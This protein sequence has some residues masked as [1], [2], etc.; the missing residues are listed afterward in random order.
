[1]PGSRP[2][3]CRGTRLKVDLSLPGEFE[4]VPAVEWEQFPSE[5]RVP[6]A[7][8][9]VVLAGA[10]RIDPAATA[11]EIAPTSA[12]VLIEYSQ[13]PTADGWVHYSVYAPNWNGGS[14]R[15]AERASR[16]AG[17]R[18][19]AASGNDASLL[20]AGPPAAAP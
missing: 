6:A 10:R 13:S 11:A 19:S 3:R 2:R 20:H 15:R 4:W 18:W 5:R 8:G 16:S 17:E 14:R 1:V 12:A 9:E 7:S